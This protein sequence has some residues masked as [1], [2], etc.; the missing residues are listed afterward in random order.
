MVAVLLSEVRGEVGFEGGKRR[1]SSVQFQFSLSTQTSCVAKIRSANKN[2]SLP[3]VALPV[4]I[5]H[6]INRRCIQAI[7]IG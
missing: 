3:L 1:P 7:A 2:K 4:P 5:Y 6:D